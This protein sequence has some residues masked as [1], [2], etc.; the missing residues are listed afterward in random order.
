MG[1]KGPYLEGKDFHVLQAH[2][3]VVPEGLKLP[4]V[5]KTGT[6][7]PQGGVDGGDS[8]R[9]AIRKGDGEVVFVAPICAPPLGGPKVGGR[10]EERE[11]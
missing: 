7:R 6:V 3:G 4:H 5:H 11:D 8:R 1:G 2:L 10:E 9:R